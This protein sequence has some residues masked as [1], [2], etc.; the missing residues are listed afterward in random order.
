MGLLLRAECGDASIQRFGI[1]ALMAFNDDIVLL[2]C[3]EVRDLALHKLA[4]A[5][6]E[7][8]PEMNFGLCHCH[9]GRQQGTG[10]RKGT[11]Q[12]LFHVSSKAPHQVRH[13]I[14][15]GSFTVCRSANWHKDNAPKI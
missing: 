13:S 6:G 14:F 3:I 1:V 10:D 4:K 15:L 5:T 2:A 11:N 9:H 8:V 12:A 7:S